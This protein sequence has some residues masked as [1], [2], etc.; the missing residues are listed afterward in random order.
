MEFRDRDQK[1]E[2]KIRPDNYGKIGVRHTIAPGT[3]ARKYNRFILITG[4]TL[5]Q[6][7][8]YFI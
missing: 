7:N 6:T 4:R 2:K 1:E 3:S 5:K 8:E